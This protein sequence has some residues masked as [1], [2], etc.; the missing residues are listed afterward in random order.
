VK[1]D[2]MDRA[3]S[4]HIREIN[5]RFWRESQKEREYQADVEAGRRTILKWTLEN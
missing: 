2:E 5:V 1:E 4:T 3:C